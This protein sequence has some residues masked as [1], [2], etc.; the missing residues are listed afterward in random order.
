MESLATQLARKTSP[1]GIPEFE[2]TLVT[3]I[4]RGNFDDSS[5]PFKIVRNPDVFQLANLVRKS[6]LLHVAGPA[7]LPVLLAKVLRRE[8]V[9]EHHGYQAICL[10]GAL[11]QE[12]ARNVCPGHFQGLEFWGMH[13]VQNE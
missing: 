13:P 4:P 5:L 3:N 7:F 9:V 12:P 8:V 6:D 11:L 2:V 1:E 10:N